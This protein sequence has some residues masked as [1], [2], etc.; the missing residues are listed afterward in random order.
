MHIKFKNIGS[1]AGWVGFGVIVYSAIH[2][3]ISYLILWG[4]YGKKWID[5]T[6]GP[7][8]IGTNI[9]G[10]AAVT[11]I[12]MEIVGHRLTPLFFKKMCVRSGTK[13][14]YSVSGLILYSII[15]LALEIGMGAV[16][17][18]FFNF[19]VYDRIYCAHLIPA[20]QLSN[21][22]N[23]IKGSWNREYAIIGYGCGAMYVIY[24][25]SKARSRDA[26]V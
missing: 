12:P 19:V 7:D 25:T 18:A 26:V 10:M 5:G 9:W 20:D 14:G 6:M 23:C 8:Q 15:V 22:P 1:K 16:L 4:I 3:G 17:Y 13:W 2:Y 24:L 11:W 21:Y